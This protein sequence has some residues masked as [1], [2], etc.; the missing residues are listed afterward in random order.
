MSTLKPI[1]MAKKHT[2]C[3]HY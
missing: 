2:H 1:K 3:R